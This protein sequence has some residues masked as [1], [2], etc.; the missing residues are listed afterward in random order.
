MG[1]EHTVLVLV[2]DTGYYTFLHI[3]VFLSTYDPIFLTSFTY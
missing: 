3:L 2:V 1:I